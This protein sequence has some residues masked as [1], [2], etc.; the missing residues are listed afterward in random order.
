[1]TQVW[2]TDRLFPSRI[3]VDSRAGALQ[4]ASEWRQR[5]TVW[6]DGSRIESGKA[7]AAYV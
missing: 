7:G 5:D 3:V 6:I 1:M 2:G 4:T